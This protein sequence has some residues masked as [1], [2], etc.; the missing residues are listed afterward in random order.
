MGCSRT[1][2]V[3]NWYGPWAPPRTPGATGWNDQ[4]DPNRCTVAG[5][6]PGPTGSRDGNDPTH[7][8]F[9]IDALRVGSAFV[10]AAGQVFAQAT[11]S[12][13][14]KLAHPRWMDFAEAEARRFK[15]ATEGEIEKTIN[16][17]KE[18][19]I[20]NGTLVGDAGEWCA[21][22]VNW[23][24]MQAKVPVVNAGES[25]Y[26]MVRVES[27]RRLDNVKPDTSSKKAIQPRNP[28]FTEVPDPVFGAIGMVING[29]GNGSHVGFVYSQPDAKTIVLLGGNQSDRVKFS[30]KALA[31]RTAQANTLK[32]FLPASYATLATLKSTLLG[33]KTANTLNDEFGIQAPKEGGNAQES[34]R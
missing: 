11:Q 6:T 25:K 4:S 2:G 31:T 3:D 15:G 18:V 21:A 27:F 22:F 30:S 7:A 34:T 10:T 13:V 19:G 17:Q 12:V 8:I 9:G 33:A 14:D 5:D 24:L 26:A 32:F 23:C 16:Y 28:L 20:T 1:P 29:V